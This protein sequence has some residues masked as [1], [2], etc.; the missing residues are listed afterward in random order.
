[1]KPLKIGDIDIFWLKGGDFRLDGG[2]MF[3][4]VPKLLWQKRYEVDKDNL[5]PLC[6]D[7]ILVRTPDNNII[8]DTGLGN[9]LNKKQ[10]AIFHLSPPW[11]VPAQ[12]AEL[13]LSR[14]DID[15]V[16]LTHCD[17]D[18]AGGVVMYN[19]KGDEELTWP[20]A[21]HI[22]QVKEWQDV[23]RPC[24]RA[25]STYWPQNFNELKRSG[26]IKLIEGDRQICDGVKVR[27]SGGHT[28]GHQI[29]EIRSGGETAVHLGDLF[30]THAQINPL[31]VMAYD[32]FPLQVID[33]KEE[34]F[35]EYGKKN[36]WFL[37]YH[38]PFMRG[39]RLSNDLKI[40]ETW[41]HR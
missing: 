10:Q 6:N 18:H 35:A 33:R 29:V 36:S 13:G 39:C 3:G 32:N 4:P 25:K 9:K 11:D 28:R 31:W 20:N 24:R 40:A 34:Y 38:D 14:N 22:I 12:L 26:S 7:P 21:L 1:M 23:E 41:P 15:I 19:E 27:S 37:F 2:T 8:I 16:I 17:F 30:P 5:I